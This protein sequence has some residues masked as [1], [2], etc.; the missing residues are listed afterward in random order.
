MMMMENAKVLLLLLLLNKTS[1]PDFFLRSS[2]RTFTER[3]SMTLVLTLEF[4]Q[5]SKSTGHKWCAQS[6]IKCQAQQ[7]QHNALGQV[8]WN[9][10]Q[11]KIE[12]NSE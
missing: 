8:L 7:Q 10:V 5:S 2:P 4:R 11:K 1:S 9:I 12:I 3:V 6:F